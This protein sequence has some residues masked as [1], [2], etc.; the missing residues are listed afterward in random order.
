MTTCSHSA[1]HCHTHSKLLCTLYTLSHSIFAL[2]TPWTGTFIEMS[3]IHFL[4]LNPTSHRWLNNWISFFVF[5]QTK[6]SASELFLSVK[7]QNFLCALHKQQIRLV[8]TFVGHRAPSKGLNAV[9]VLLWALWAATT[10]ESASSSS[11]QWSLIIPCNGMLIFDR[12]DHF[13]TV[14]DL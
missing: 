9:R 13:D 11:G 7:D 12:W 8:L 2:Q 3:N 4:E 1:H 14:C 10:I 5:L 6:D